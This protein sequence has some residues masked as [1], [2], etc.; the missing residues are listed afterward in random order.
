MIGYPDVRPTLPARR[1]RHVGDRRLSVRVRRMTVEHAGDVRVLDK[2][3]KPVLA[4]RLDF[5][6]SFPQLRRHPLEA[7]VRIDIGFLG[8]GEWTGIAHEGVSDDLDPALREARANGVEVFRATRC[9]PERD[10]E[11]GRLDAIEIHL[12]SVDI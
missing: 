1:I 6:Q 2:R 9:A 10:S 12:R 8:A 7:G 3:R 4:G 5:T 11:L